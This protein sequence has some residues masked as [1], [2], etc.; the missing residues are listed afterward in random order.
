VDAQLPA[1]AYR[2]SRLMPVQT[3]FQ[4]AAAQRMRRVQSREPSPRREESFLPRKSIG[5]A[6]N[7]APNRTAPP[8]MSAGVGRAT[9]AG[10]AVLTPLADCHDGGG[11]CRSNAATLKA[12]DV[13][14]VVTNG[15]VKVEP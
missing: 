6:I 3:V 9:V 7:A 5:T 2:R 11:V 10:D 12:D 1:A 8:I 13:C 14:G 15:I 4:R